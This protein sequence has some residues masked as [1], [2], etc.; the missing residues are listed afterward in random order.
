M[1]WGRCNHGPL[2]ALIESEMKDLPRSAG[3]KKLIE[4]GIIRVLHGMAGVDYTREIPIE[5]SR[6]ISAAALEIC[7]LIRRKL[8][9]LRSDS[10]ERT[11]T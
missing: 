7:R 4:K 5:H 9:P 3:K 10:N 6:I 2:E 8:P 11:R 1:K